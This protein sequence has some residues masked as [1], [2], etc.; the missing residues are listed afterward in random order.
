MGCVKE[1]FSEHSLPLVQIGREKAGSLPNESAGVWALFE[2]FDIPSSPESL[3]INGVEGLWDQQPQIGVSKTEVRLRG[4]EC[5]IY[6]FGSAF[7]LLL[8]PVN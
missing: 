7:S 4:W 2:P 5:F 1:A 6:E 8:E 3:L